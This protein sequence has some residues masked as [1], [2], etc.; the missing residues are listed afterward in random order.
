MFCMLEESEKF[1]IISLF[2]LWLSASGVLFL[3]LHNFINCKVDI[4]CGTE[5]KQ[6]V[7][8][9]QELKCSTH[10]STLVKFNLKKI[11]NVVEPRKCIKWQIFIQI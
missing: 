1:L 6:W 11:S 3:L 2:I 5:N 9:T 7:G 10:L 8:C 4:I